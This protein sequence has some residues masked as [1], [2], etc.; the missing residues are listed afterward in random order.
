[1]QYESTD[2]NETL[3]TIGNIDNRIARYELAQRIT[4]LEEF[5]AEKIDGLGR[6]RR[7]I[8]S[9]FGMME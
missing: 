5:Y 3:K 4:G 8:I 6:E 9:G 7:G 2:T 1:M